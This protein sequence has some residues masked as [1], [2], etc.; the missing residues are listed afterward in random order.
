MTLGCSISLQILSPGTTTLS[1]KYLLT[2]KL[3]RKGAAQGVTASLWKPCSTSS[4]V[5]TLWMSKGDFMWQPHLALKVSL[6][7]IFLCFGVSCT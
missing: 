5:N 3:H 4:F 1:N 2:F 7:F 6:P